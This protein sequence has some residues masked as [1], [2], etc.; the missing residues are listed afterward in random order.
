MDTA[1][2]Q[3]LKD[4]GLPADPD[5][6]SVGVPREHGK[7]A[8]EDGLL[9]LVGARAGTALVEPKRIAELFVGDRQPPPMK[10]GPPEEYFSFF[11]ALE[12]CAALACEARGRP[13]VDEEFER[14]YR[15]LRR[16]PDGVDRNPVFGC[17]Q[18]A[19]RVYM[20]LADVSQAEYEAVM[21]R[22]SK[23]ARTFHTHV[24]ST[25]YFENALSPLL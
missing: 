16:R 25:N 1:F 6:L 24:G 23:S 7:L 12:H 8:Q 2:I 9:V 18:R 17:I 15:Q 20:S 4:A 3:K 22:L 19:A 21:N 11:F 13:E 10:G 5:K 14:I